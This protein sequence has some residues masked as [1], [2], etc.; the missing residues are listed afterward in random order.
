VASLF[1][2]ILEGEIPGRF[3]WRD[4]QCGAFLTI[5]PLKPGHTLLVPR[6]EVDHWIDLDP[7][8]AQHLMVVAQHLGQ[9]IQRA[10]G[11]EKVGVAIVGLEV[12]HVHIHLSPI[13][14]IADLDFSRQDKH[15]KPADLDAAAEAIR[16][17]LRELG[18]D[19]QAQAIR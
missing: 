7:R 10:F 15:P 8:L 19:R 3:V 14:H 4:D 2:K 13:W 12:R 11:P 16:S 5:A 18:L 9:A 6:A 17:S 1:T